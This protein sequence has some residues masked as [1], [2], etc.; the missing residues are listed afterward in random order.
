MKVGPVTGENNAKVFFKH[1]LF[2]FFCPQAELE[3]IVLDVGR[4]DEFQVRRLRLN[5]PP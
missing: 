3:V 1:S 4:V 5:D 2:L